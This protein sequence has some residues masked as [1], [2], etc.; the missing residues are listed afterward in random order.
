MKVL[1]VLFFILNILVWI[2]AHP[3]MGLKNLLNITS[4]ILVL[5]PIYLA[6]S[7]RHGWK[8]LFNLKFH[9]DVWVKNGKEQ[10]D[11][12]KTIAYTALMTGALG[13]S[14]GL[15]IQFNQ[16]NDPNAIDQ[17]FVSSMG[18][19][20]LTSLYALLIFLIVVLIYFVGREDKS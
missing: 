19:S 17:L 5:L 18:I 15:I 9:T 13:M 6:I 16:L 7:Y 1:C 2:L 12:L 4:L 10:D 3:N 11:L 14:I 20:L 8:S